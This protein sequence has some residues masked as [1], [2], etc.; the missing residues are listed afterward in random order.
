MGLWRR[1][2]GGMGIQVRRLSPE[3]LRHLL[4]DLADILLDCVRGG[5][6]VSFMHSL[7]EPDALDYFEGIVRSVERG[8]RILFGA[9]QDTL[10][11][12]TV[13][14]VLAMPPNQPHRA[15]VAKLLVHRK[16]RGQ[17]AG[18]L[19]MEGVERTSREAGRTLL[20]LDTA[21]GSAAQSL[22]ASMG[23]NRL[24][25]IPGYALTPDGTPCGTTF[26][27]KR[28]DDY[29]PATSTR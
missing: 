10:L 7:T 6:S 27:W 17:G 3:E 16:A 21:E 11:I 26:F 15:D 24:G 9:F 25:T 8:E 29:P 23:W 18:R 1:E 5:A 19:L 2:L 22:Y 4:R 14:L 28:V 12:G 20:V 13:Q